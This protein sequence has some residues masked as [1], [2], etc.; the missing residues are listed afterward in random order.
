[1]HAH[2]YD[3][4]SFS[5]TLRR[6]VIALACLVIHGTSVQAQT[7]FLDTNGDGVSGLLETLNGSNTPYDCLNSGTTAFDVYLV[8][9]QNPDGTAV[10]CNSSTNPLTISSYQ[11]I[12]R[13]SGA[14]GVA[15]TGWTDNMGFDTPF[16]TDGDGT[17][18]ASG[19]EIWIGRSGA[20]LSAGKYKL[21]T[22][23]VAVTGTPVLD[24]VTSAYPWPA[25]ITAFGSDCSGT[26][27][28][29]MLVF[30]ED[31]PI[32]VG[33]GTCRSDDVVPITWGKIKRQY[34]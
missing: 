22:L 32:S 24:F 15:V 23:S 27:V 2:C 25:A 19:Q 3:A 31:F 16:I 20:S 6:M 1:M 28:E 14:G 34:R 13:T 5:S 26:L 11:V 4:D 8:T 10:V 29:G 17:L 12:L 9:N 7:L 18:A 21:G 30:G 33:F